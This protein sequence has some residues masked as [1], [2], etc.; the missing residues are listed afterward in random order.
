M[1]MPH[2]C[3]HPVSALR[4]KQRLG[5]VVHSLAKAKLPL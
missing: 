3:R 2:L 4:W 1:I 5:L